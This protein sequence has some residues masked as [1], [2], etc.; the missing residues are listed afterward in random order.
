MAI[1]FFAVMLL[2]LWAVIVLPQQRRMKAHQAVVATLEVGDEI[3]TTSGIM[4]TIVD[5][6]DEV[7]SVEVAPGT[8]L[9]FVRGAIA[10]KVEPEDELDADELESDDDDGDA[11]EDDDVV[12][13]EGVASADVTEDAETS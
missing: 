1:V 13:D 4:G 12:L 9:R 2:L 7:V 11:D 8:A 6:D 5:M 3:M 10:R